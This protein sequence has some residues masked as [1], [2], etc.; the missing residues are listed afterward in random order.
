MKAKIKMNSPSYPI[1]NEPLMERIAKTGGTKYHHVLYFNALMKTGTAKDGVEKLIGLHSN[2][3]GLHGF[4][5]GFQYVSLEGSGDESANLI[6]IKNAIFFLR[7]VGFLASLSGTL[8]SLVS[9]EFLKL[10]LDEEPEFQV[11]GALKYGEFFG[12]SDRLA[13][14]ASVALAATVNMIIYTHGLP[15]ILC[16]VINGIS[17]LFLI[18]FLLQFKRMIVDKQTVGPGRNLYEFKKSGN[19]LDG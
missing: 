11:E 7:L 8:V 14:L 5:A 4:M 2:M 9:I 17:V 3:L 16:Y 19:I 12:I 13:I 1:P 15:N 10:G 6:S 18:C